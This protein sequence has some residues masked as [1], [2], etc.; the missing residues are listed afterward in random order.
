M[1][2][3]DARRGQSSQ[4]AA[5][6][7]RAK[8]REPSTDARRAQ[9]VQRA[10]PARRD[11]ARTRR[12]VTAAR[13][14]VRSGKS[15][16]RA[17]TGD[18]T[19]GT[20]VA[21]GERKRAA[22]AAAV[23]RQRR[24]LANAPMQTAGLGGLGGLLSSISGDSIRD[25]ARDIA[26]LQA[27]AVSDLVNLP[28]HA[29]TG[30]YEL[31][32]AGYE[33]TQATDPTLDR[34]LPGKGSTERGER[35]LRGL[36]DGMLGRLIL[37]GDPKGAAKAFSEHPLYSAL[38]VTGAGQ[39]VGRSAGAVGR[40]GLA[41]GAAKARTSQKREPLT[42]VPGTNQ[43][44]AR[45]YSP[46]QIVKEAQLARER[47]LR[48]RG[49]DPNATR[50]QA[51]SYRM[52][53]EVD[54]FAGQAEGMRR[55]GRT[56]MG[57][58]GAKMAPVRRGVEATTRRGKAAAAIDRGRS[59]G[60][61]NSSLPGR[62]GRAERGVTMAA[63]EGR[64]RGPKSFVADLKRERDRLQK[65]YV[66][67]RTTMS[68]ATRRDNTAQRRDLDRMLKVVAENPGKRDLI[69]REVFRAADE[70]KA[71]QDRIEGELIREAG[72][73]PV[74]ADTARLRTYG[75]SVMGLRPSQT[76]RAPEHL[77]ERHAQ[78][79]ARERAAREQ[80]SAAVKRERGERDR[81]ARISG[82]NQAKRARDTREKGA[83]R[84]Y[85]V[86]DKRFTDRGA[87]DKLAKEKGAKVRVVAT[88]VREADRS[89]RRAQ[90]ERRVARAV[91]KRKE[92]QAAYVAAR[93]AR[94]GS[95][96]TRRVS[97]L[98]DADGN[99]VAL[100]AIKEHIAKHGDREPAFVGHRRADR[101]AASHFVNW[102]GS[103]KD[104]GGGKRRTGEAART[105]G[106]DA[107]FNALTENL[108]RGQG[109][110][111]AIKAADQFAGQFGTK[112]PD[113][114]PFTW[115][116][117]EA[118]KGNLAEATGL[119][120]VPY[121]MAA[122]RHDAA[123]MQK[124]LDEQGSA[125][126]PGDLESLTVGRLQDALKPPPGGRQ[127]ARNVVL[128]P[129][130]QMQR[131]TEHQTKGSNTAQKGMQVLSRQ[132][133]NTVLPFS[134]PWVFGN[135]GE[136][137]LRLAFHGVT[138]VDVAYR[139]PRYMRAL[140]QMDEQTW[141]KMDT[142]VRGGLLFG[143]GDQLNIRRGSEDF[144]GS[145]AHV[146]AM[147]LTTAVRLPVF[148]EAIGAVR[149]FTS[150]VQRANRGIERI[151]QTGVIGKA[152][153][154]DA[155]DLT[156]SWLKASLLQED[157]VKELAR[158]HTGTDKMFQYA[159]LSDHILGQY[160][161]YGPGTR[162]FIQTY[163]PFLP[164]AINAAR[165]SLWTLP[166]KH[167]VKA[168][169]LANVEM[170]LA[171]EIEEA[172]KR[173]PGPLR[174]AIRRKDGG[175]VNIARYSPFAL[176]T[177]GP[178][179]IDDQLLPQ[180]KAFGV[181]A[182]QAWTGRP[183]RDSDGKPI[184]SGSGKAFALGLYSMLEATIPGLS[185]ARRVQEKG[186]SAHDDSTV[187]APKV[188]PRKPTDKGPANRILNPLRPTYL[189]GGT[190]GGGSLGA[191]PAEERALQREEKA[192]LEQQSSAAGRAE[193]EALKREERA[194]LRSLGR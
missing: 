168:A 96:P 151:Y 166:A 161:R 17:D 122:A 105:G 12:D 191:S 150:M 50:G 125:S 118:V 188:K 116:E 47:S 81:A 53:R 192:L 123:T 13:A 128:V 112:R 169:L 164:W 9:S 72:L 97:G 153:R 146:P 156:D 76:A 11:A 14:K 65:V 92:A 140:R 180:F 46:N 187:F 177:E 20:R 31:G 41:G 189:K 141:R 185:V 106:Y 100:A 2:S 165:F 88:N 16:L 36:D 176:A 34:L 152:V 137:A 75:V 160:S 158:G 67:E 186:Q 120:W 5:S 25:V 24:A 190:G 68:A 107:S 35:L 114:K 54:A 30:L 33:A 4:R 110:V 143:S 115:R 60:L 42:V 95:K 94:A 28:K 149:G 83:Q 194:L 15:S 89:G 121:R 147:G 87:A 139:G 23:E 61:E 52:N 113:G 29:V 27:R 163:A 155:R 167:P 157:I 69:A 109:V 135:A 3:L 129:A 179:I 90:A 56:E 99:P 131:F 82:S 86:G 130:Q 148:K 142:N 175:L 119:E 19:R 117:A 101:G 136:G 111:D 32:A 144:K 181:M 59:R 183:L 162:H 80:L 154:N 21:P 108:V 104:P 138:P 132:F 43:S 66:A 63:A 18:V 37:H 78:A 193:E 7:R 40:S 98:E 74:Q 51:R 170:T 1:P 8:R 77:E 91:Q 57:R 44:V 159:R 145:V 178:A 62:R 22:R 102:F 126:I 184:E 93:K 73:D 49:L 48:N 26:G 55:R 79:G 45:R 84:A 172:K 127:E 174:S 10:A 70:Y 38:E 133:R 171:Q 39:V 85:Y 182:G 134:V 6:T 124:I 103:R 64:L 173:P 58:A 71:H